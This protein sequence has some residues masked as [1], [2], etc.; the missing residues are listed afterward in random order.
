V[1]RAV[2]LIA[3]AGLLL[4]TACSSGVR[5]VVPSPSRS[6]PSSTGSSPSGS[7]ST[8]PT[9]PSATS[10]SSDPAVV[11]Q[12][13]FR[14]KSSGWGTEK[15]PSGTQF[16]YGIN[17][18]VV[19]ARGGGNHTQYAPHPA[20][21]RPGATATFALPRSAPAGTAVGVTCRGGP[22]S[23]GTEVQFLVD[24]RAG[25]WRIELYSGAAI[26]TDSTKVV[27]RGR[28][29][30]TPPATPFAVTG[31][32][33]TQAGGKVTRA[34]LLVDG[35]AVGDRRVATDPSDSAEWRTGLTVSDV[36]RGATTVVVTS[37]EVRFYPE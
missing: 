24:P 26:S 27:A 12:D 21:A 9:S 33:L 22:D 35:K 6:G 8:A 15:L 36:D 28:T 11:F 25:T 7:A 19:I 1:R 37:Y 34:V 4:L 31:R 20:I 30:V 14:S 29:K 23:A 32:C 13:D 3:G 2:A 18:Y 17:S 5:E 16:L 10:S